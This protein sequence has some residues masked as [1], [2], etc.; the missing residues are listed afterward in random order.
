M[1]KS[2]LL[3]LAFVST[4]MFLFSSTFAQ[5]ADD[6]TEDN[7]TA[8]YQTAGTNFRVYVEPDLA[9][10]PSYNHA[11]QT[12]ISANARWQFTISAGLTLVLPA[13][14]S[15]PVAQNWVELTAVT[16]GAQSLTA[17]E[18][19]TISSCAD[20]DAETQVVNVTGAPTAEID[21]TNTPA[22]AWNE[23]SAGYEYNACDSKAAETIN[24]TITETGV[25]ALLQTYAYSV[26][27]R[28]VILDDASAEES[29]V[30]TTNIIDHTVATKGLT[31]TVTTG[32]LDVLT[33]D[34]GSGTAIPSR[35]MYEYT[36]APAT[37]AVAGITGI[38]SAVS[39][40]SDY[41]ALALDA[42]DFTDYAF[43]GT[44]VVTYIVNPTPVTGPI[45]HIPIN[46][47]D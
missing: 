4:A 9:Y 2:T 32:A 21:G 7:A 28:V 43:T 11:A 46:F 27:K 13:D 1:R 35:T 16:V 42:T 17:L 5:V 36:L 24:V 34:W 20:A 8:M 33:Y 47:N 23:V 18:S 3:K 37:D 41:L 39:H 12:G 44:L 6:Y 15:T 10:S 29:V 40:K 31:A 19:N 25:P 30:S 45:Y 22:N 26:Q 14:I 38:I